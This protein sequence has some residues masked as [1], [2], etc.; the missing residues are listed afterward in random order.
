MQN[1]K[2]EELQQSLQALESER[3]TLVTAQKAGGK[4][5]TADK[6]ER[7]EALLMEIMDVQDDIADLATPEDTSKEEAYVPKPGTEGF[8]HV[9]MTKG[10]KFDPNTGEQISKPFVQVYTPGEYKH[11]AKFGEALGYCN[12]EVLWDPTKNK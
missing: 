2:L 6:Q 10:K 9:Q 1:K 12:I 4:A 11:F 5:W 7:L 3:D 8:Y